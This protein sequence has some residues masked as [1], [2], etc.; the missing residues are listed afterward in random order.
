MPEDLLELEAETT[1]EQQPTEETTETPETET[2]TEETGDKTPVTS[3]FQSDGKKL[4]PQVSATLTKIKT[5]NPE[6]GKLLT[7]AVYRVAEIDREFPGGVSE[8]KELRDKVEEFGGVDS[9]EQ[10]LESLQEMD[11]LATAFMNSDPAFVEDLVASSPEAFAA[12]APIVF[13]KFAEVNAEGFSAYMGRVVIQDF[14]AN[15]LPLMMMR[16]QDLIPAD[17]AKLREA[18]D[19]VNGYLGGFKALAKKPLPSAKANASKPGTKDD[20]TKREEAL[21]AKEWQGERDTIQKGIVNGEYSK[22]LAGKKPNTEEKAQIR[23]LFTSR[24][25]AAADKLFPGWSEKAQKYINNNDKQGFLRYMTSI[26]KR[27]VPEAM[28]SAVRST[29]K[30]ARATTTTTTRKP[31]T[32]ASRTV[33]AEGFKPVVNEPGSWDVDYN[34]TTRAMLSENRA[35]LKDGTKVAWR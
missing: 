10:K 2:P 22:C 13:Q 18:F 5:E 7:R 24:S 4:D 35:I 27:I 21:R 1:E 23:E 33:V 25:K 9:I 15:Q 28:A 34:R 6:L 8:A 14:Q 16:L 12:L 11:G 3:L 19:H 31:G 30:G 32:P 20:L 29:M 17:N 26:Y